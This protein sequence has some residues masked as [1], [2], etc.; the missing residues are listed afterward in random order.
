LLDRRLYGAEGPPGEAAIDAAVTLAVDLFM[1]YY[2]LDD[3]GGR[4]AA[5][6]AV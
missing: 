5:A 4:Q 6:A 3:D 1:H 2:G